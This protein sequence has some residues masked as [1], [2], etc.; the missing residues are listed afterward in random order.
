MLL[1]ATGSILTREFFDGQWLLLIGL[2]LTMGSFGAGELLRGL[3]SGSHRFA[4]YATYFGLEGLV[5]FIAAIGLGL[6]SV[7]VAGPYGLVVALGPAVAVVVAGRGQRDLLRPG[8]GLEWRELTPALG[9]LLAASLFE[10]F[11]LNAG[12]AAV[13]LLTGEGEDDAAGRFLNGLL[14]ARVPLFFFQAVK[15]SLLPNLARLAGVGNWDE[16]RA[17]LVRLLTFVAA[18]G[19]A[20]IVGAYLLGPFVVE[21]AFGDEI[22]RSDMALLALSSALFMGALSLA[23]TL[24]AVGA[25]AKVA[26]GWLPG[27]VLFPIAVAVMSGDDFLRVE[28]G[29]IASIGLAAVVMAAIARH[30]IRRVRALAPAGHS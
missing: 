12:V 16:F 18:I 24:I 6:A 11:L 27:V 14:M 5:R 2:I 10:A 30:E 21:T 9:F 4:A 25:Q 20:G 8:A 13:R 22:G 26:L 15:A 19:S 28:V 1:L 7:E 23:L 17:T 3:L 29:L